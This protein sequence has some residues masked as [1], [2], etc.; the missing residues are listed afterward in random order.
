MTSRFVSNVLVLIASAVLVTFSLVFPPA[1]VAWIALG[2]GSLVAVIV[3]AAFAMRGRGV[4][5]RIVDVLMILSGAW[6]IVASRTFSGAPLKWITFGTGALL[7]FF[8]LVGL[9]V[10]EIS[11]ELA[12]R[13]LARGSSDGRAPASRHDQ[14]PAR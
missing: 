14:V 5:Q 7:A 11:M 4:G 2:L 8:A 9:V 3:L 10:H 13:P 6:L 1:V 12:V